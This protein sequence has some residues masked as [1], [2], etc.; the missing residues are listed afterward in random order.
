VPRFSLAAQSL[1]VYA[2][3]IVHGWPLIL[4]AIGALMQRFVFERFR[5]SRRSD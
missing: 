2:S 4:R 1:G 5:R 3:K